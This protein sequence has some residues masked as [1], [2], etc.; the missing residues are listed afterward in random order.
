MNFAEQKTINIEELAAQYKVVAE[1]LE[2]DNLFPGFADR[3]NEVLDKI[4]PDLPTLY[5]RPAALAAVLGLTKATTGRWFKDN[6]PPNSL[7]MR[8][9]S[10]WLAYN[11]D[12]LTSKEMEIYLL[13]GEMPA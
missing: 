1:G 11:T 12:F 5:G 3:L 9:L 6:K 4:Q 13:Y 8:K 2:D 7:S 10:A